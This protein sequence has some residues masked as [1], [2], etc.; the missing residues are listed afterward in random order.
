[1]NTQEINNISYKESSNLNIHEDKLQQEPNNPIII[2]EFDNKDVPLNDI[3]NSNN[4]DL[5]N[6]ILK[7]LI[8]SLKHLQ[9]KKMIV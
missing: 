7:K 5:S 6:Y 3:N 8:A 9:L 2:E 4:Q 1:M